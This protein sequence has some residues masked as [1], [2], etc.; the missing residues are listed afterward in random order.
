MRCEDVA[1]EDQPGSLTYMERWRSEIS[2]TSNIVNCRVC[3]HEVTYL[4][5]RAICQRL[6]FGVLSVHFLPADFVL[7]LEH[8]SVAT[9]EVVRVKVTSH[10]LL[11]ICGNK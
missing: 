10:V 7:A 9:V 4:R 8:N 6:M 2:L 3:I 1:R 5:T 11:I